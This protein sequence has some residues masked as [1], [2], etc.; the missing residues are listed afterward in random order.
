MTTAAFGNSLVALERQYMLGSRHWLRTVYDLR[1]GCD[2][3]SQSM[4]VHGV[5]HA[6]VRHLAALAVLALRPLGPHWSP[7][8]YGFMARA[9]SGLLKAFP[10][11]QVRH[12]SLHNAA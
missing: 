7:A 4:V 6:G 3:L 12:V 10:L 5:D 2:A 8:G 9:W 1:S 11:S